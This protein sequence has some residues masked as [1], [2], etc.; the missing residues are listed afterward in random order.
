MVGWPNSNLYTPITRY[1]ETQ[2]TDVYTGKIKYEEEKDMHRQQSNSG[3]VPM[4]I[5]SILQQLLCRK[6][7]VKHDITVTELYTA[8]IVVS[9]KVLLYH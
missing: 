7:S 8:T 4:P 6:I 2:Q 9:K 5:A 3:Q 1:D